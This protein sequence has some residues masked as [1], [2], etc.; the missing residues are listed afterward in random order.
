[1]IPAE[2]FER[3]LATDPREVGCDEVMDVLH[4]YVDLLATGVDA[5]TQYPGVAVH[6]EDCEPCSEDVRGLLAAIRA[7]DAEPTPGT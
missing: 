2:L 4:V 3:F 5:S 1:M 6:L 7:T